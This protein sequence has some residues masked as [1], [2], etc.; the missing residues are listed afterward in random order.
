MPPKGKKLGAGKKV[1][2]KENVKKRVEP[3]VVVTMTRAKR[4]KK[5]N[6]M[7]AF[8]EVTILEEAAYVLFPQPV[9]AS[10]A[11]ARGCK[12]ARVV[13]GPLVGWPEPQPGTDAMAIYP[14][15]ITDVRKDLDDS[16]YHWKSGHV[17]N[18]DFGGSG[19]GNTNMT[20]LTSSANTQQTAFDNN[21]K[22]ARS[23]LHKVYST[24]REAGGQQDFFTALGYGG[25]FNAH[26]VEI[27]SDDD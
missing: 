20:C 26:F 7:D 2:I 25:L 4:L 27:Q 6:S 17:I 13:L 21:V 10:T 18:A 15:A 11:G 16:K 1:A 23:A 14:D 8:G 3:T 5:Q 9:G 22:K 19:I 24:I 12:S